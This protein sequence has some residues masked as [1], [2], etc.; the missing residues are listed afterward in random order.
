MSLLSVLEAVELQLFLCAEPHLEEK[1]IDVVP[2][3]PRQLNHLSILR[4]LDNCSIAGKLLH[5]ERERERER[6]ERGRVFVCDFGTASTS[7][8]YTI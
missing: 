3:V 1:V 8:S 5:P 7:P 4:V 2:L 6:R